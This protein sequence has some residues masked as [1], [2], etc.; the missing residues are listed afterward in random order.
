MSSSGQFMEVRIKKNTGTYGALAGATGAKLFTRASIE[1]NLKKNTYQS[2]RIKKSQQ[3]SDWRHGTKRVEGT[4]KDE[5]ACSAFQDLLAA[6]LRTAWANG[7]TSGALTNVT[8]SA[9]APHF[10]RA[11][12]SWITDGFRVGALVRPSGWTT[13]GAVNNGKNFVIT[14]LTATN[15]SVAE[16]GQETTTVGAKAAGDSVTFVEQGKTLIVPQ[17]GH[18]KDDFNVELLYTDFTPNR[19]EVGV[20]MVPTGFT[21]DVKPDNMVGVEFPMIGKDRVDSDAGQ[22]FTTP[23]AADT[24]RTFGSAIG[25]L[26]L[27][28]TLAL[29]I[30]GITVTVKGNHQPGNPVLTP[31]INRVFPGRV[32]V[33]GTL[34]GYLVDFSMR[35]AFRDETEGNI[36]FYLSQQAAALA[37][38][39]GAILPRVKLGEVG[40]QDSETMFMQNIP[41]EALENDTATG[42]DLT[43]IRLQDTTL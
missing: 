23:G 6:A 40:I 38:C 30:T 43:T 4:L 14:A 13:T 8:A 26:Y 28:G 41:F 10:V 22:Y 5:L 19:S 18:T 21:I 16:V 32:E 3:R 31:S 27:Y 36:I 12:G 37:D 29:H 42:S 15:M 33:S 35:N 24:H 11:A 34:S 17:T 20:G 39:F 2:A 25:L 9:V 1:L 7:A